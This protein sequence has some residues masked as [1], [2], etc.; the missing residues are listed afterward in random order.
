MSWQLLKDKQKILRILEHLI[1]NKTDMTV[2]IENEEDLFTTKLIKINKENLSSRIYEETDLVIEKLIPEKGNSLIQSVSEMAVEFSINENLCQFFVKYVGV[3]TSYP[4][5]G[6]ILSFPESIMIK[7]KRKEE[8]IIYEQPDFISV[9]FSLGK[10]LEK[11]KVYNLNVIDSSVY[12][13]GLLINQTN[14][15]LLHLLDPGDTIKDITFF[16]KWAMIKVDGTV[17]HKTEIME[18]KYKGCYVLGIESP[19]IIQGF[20]PDIS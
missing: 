1:D 2:R 12:G 4:Y 13:L 19:E 3:S 17:R 10:G 6:L 18:G 9:E 16:S 14:F 7:E 11:D 20:R 8:R 15:D 5:F